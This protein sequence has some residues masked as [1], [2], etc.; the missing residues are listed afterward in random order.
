MRTDVQKAPERHPTILRRAV[1]GLVLVAAALLIIHFI[2]GLIV[3][4]FYV[5]A[6]LAVIVAVLWA[7][8]TIF[9]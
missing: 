2:A 7:L 8:K 1:A 5:V 9:W 6:T 3:A 4:V